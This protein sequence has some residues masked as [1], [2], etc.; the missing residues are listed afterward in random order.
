MKVLHV[1]PLGSNPASGFVHSIGGLSA[2]QSRIGVD[3]AL[4][5]SIRGGHAF[6][7]DGVRIIEASGAIHADPWR[8]GSTAARAIQASLGTPDVVVFHGT[9][10][11]FHAAFARECRNRGWPYIATSRGDLTPFAQ[12]LKRTKKRLGNMLFA[13]R[14]VRQSAAVHALTHNEANA[15]RNFEPSVRTFVVPNGVPSSLLDYRAASYGYDG[16]LRAT[17]LGRLDVPI[18]G[19]DLLLGALRLLQSSGGV[20]VQIRLIGPYHTRGD[21]AAIEAALRALPKPSAVTRDVLLEG[22]HKYSALN[23]SDVLVCTS[24]SEGMPMSVLEA[25]ALG[26]PCIVTRSANISDLIEHASAGWLAD[27]ASNTIAAALQMAAGSASERKRRGHAARD[28]VARHL[29]W[30]HVA[31]QYTA[32]LGR[33]IG[34]LHD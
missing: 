12:R 34:E 17:F 10:H 18:K 5:R 4:L 27:P 1:A 8:G 24:R 33:V 22:K 23:E 30:D 25:M 7:P 29:T 6:L 11:P 26:R 20:D 15:I 13:R 2:A 31:K 21:R 16:S 19:L 32:E 28:Y 3:V 9:Y 14:F